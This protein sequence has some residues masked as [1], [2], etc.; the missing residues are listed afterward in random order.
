MI[1]ADAITSEGKV[2]NKIGSRT[3][4]Y[5]A[6]SLGIPVYICTNSW[7]FDPETIFGFE[8][9][10]EERSPEEVWDNPPN[11]VTV[12]NPAFEMIEPT[13]IEAVISELGVYRSDVL[14]EVVKERYPEIFE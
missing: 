12:R 13:L 10:I 9:P 14:L 3:F 4:A 11:G 7:K 6:K 8:E 5:I 2:V 1:G